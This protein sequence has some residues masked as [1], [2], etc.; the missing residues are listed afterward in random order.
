MV[1]VHDPRVRWGVPASHVVR[2]MTAAEWV[3]APAIDVLAALGPAPLTGG[4]ARRVMIV[5]GAADR[6]AA[7]LALGMIDIGDVDPTDVLSLPDTLAADTPN[8]AA[9]VVA[10]D[11]SLSLLLQPSALLT[12]DDSALREEPCPSRS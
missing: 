9:I 5:R 10:P 4:L 7:L 6:E 11:A 12:P 8:I 2:I 1:H 3:D